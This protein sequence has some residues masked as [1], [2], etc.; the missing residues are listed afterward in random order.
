MTTFSLNVPNFGTTLAE[1]SY[2]KLVQVCQSAE[3]AGF[4][5]VLVTDHVVMGSDNSAYTWSA[6]P[7]EPDANWLEPLTVL[8]FVA[9]QTKTIRLGTGI[10]IAA[11]RGERYWPRRPRHSICC[12]VADSIWASEPVGRN[13]N[14]TRSVWTSAKGDHCSTTLS[15]CAGRCGVRRRRA[16]TLLD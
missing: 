10:V 5:R 2:G 14:T 6:F 1:N 8:A 12:P 9:G 16:S 4:D 7:T 15:Q 13:A 11:L 3:A